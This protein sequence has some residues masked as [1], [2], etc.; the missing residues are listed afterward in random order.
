MQTDSSSAVLR[1]EIVQWAKYNPRT[2]AKAWSWF[3]LDNDF[4]TDPDF[5]DLTTAQLLVFVY[6]CCRQSKAG[7]T[8]F[9]LNPRQTAE[10]VKSDPETILETL[11]VFEALGKIR[12]L[13]LDEA[14]R[15]TS[16]YVDVRESTFT[17]KSV[18]YE[19]TN[20]R[21]NETDGQEVDSEVDS[22]SPAKSPSPM[23]LAELWNTHRGERLPEV[24]LSTFKKGTPRWEAAKARLT[25]MPDLAY[26]LEVIQRI[27]KAD[28][29]NGTNDR[30]WKADFEFLTRVE[31]HV[32]VIEGKYDNGKVGVP[33]APHKTPFFDGDTL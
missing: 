26:W 20:E 24:R 14:R 32:K 31:S 27:A 2:E 28:F 12:I 16:T 3:R 33:P 13:P 29:C 8:V 4:F 30:K 5:Y 7:G 23:R 19:R 21:T 10:T 6:L 18:P 11:R 22:P 1:V 9:K 17:P 25:F 15:R